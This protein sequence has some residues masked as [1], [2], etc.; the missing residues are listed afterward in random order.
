MTF[1]G[2][3]TQLSKLVIITECHYNQNDKIQFKNLILYLYVYN[4]V[5]KFTINVT[6]FYHKMLTSINAEKKELFK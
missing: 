5:L 6:H 3:V 2:Q 4:I 1:K